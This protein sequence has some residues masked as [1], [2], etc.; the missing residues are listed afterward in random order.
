MEEYEDLQHPDFKMDEQYKN[1]GTLFLLEA[2]L[3]DTS[4]AETSDDEKSSVYVM[5]EK[6]ELGVG[7]KIHSESVFDKPWYLGT[8]VGDMLTRTFCA[9][10]VLGVSYGK[11]EH[12]PEIISLPH[13]EGPK[14]Y[15]LSRIGEE[16]KV[17]I[18]TAT[19]EAFEKEIT[20]KRRY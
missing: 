11:P 18:D 9:N 7:L 12:I 13:K 20:S 2:S 10:G 16:D 4:K 3:F 1:L 19:A 6:F 8:K 15:R 14:L 17:T 5:L